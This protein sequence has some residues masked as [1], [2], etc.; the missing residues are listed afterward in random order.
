MVK[1]EKWIGGN[2]IRDCDKEFRG[3]N[4]VAFGKHNTKCG[5]IW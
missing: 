3:L 2:S 1:R 4:V 5:C